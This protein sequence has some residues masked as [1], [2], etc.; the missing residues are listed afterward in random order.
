MQEEGMGVEEEFVL[1]MSLCNT[2]H[3]D[4]CYCKLEISFYTP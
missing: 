3:Y 1:P 4:E 2:T